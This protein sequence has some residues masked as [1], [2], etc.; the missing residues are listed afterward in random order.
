MTSIALLPTQA[1]AENTGEGDHPDVDYTPLSVDPEQADADVKMG[2][3]EQYVKP[4]GRRGD[5][6]A[7]VAALVSVGVFLIVT[8]VLVFTNN[9]TGLGWFFWHPVLQSLSVAHFTYGILTLQPTSQPTSK[10]AG[11]SRH[12]LI[13]LGLGLP[14]IL[15]GTLAILINKRLHGYAHFVTWHGTFGIITLAWM[16]VQVALGGGSVWLNGRLFG[17]NPRAKHV[18]KYHRYAISTRLLRGPLHDHIFF[19]VAYQVVWVPAIPH[20]VDHGAPRRCVVELGN[21]THRARCQRTCVHC[22]A[23]RAADSC[24]RPSEVLE[25]AN[26]LTHSVCH[27]NNHDARPFNEECTVSNPISK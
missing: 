19:F 18:W 21:R 7:R 22:R 9:P 23:C 8:W 4:E 26:L 13:M 6:V 25:D 2:S 20:A 10:A 16:L 5:T 24:A 1:S 12:Q 17:G 14:A 27:W 3:D 11:L 15:L